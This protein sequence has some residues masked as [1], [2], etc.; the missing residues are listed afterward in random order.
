MPRRKRENDAL[1]DPR[2]TRPQLV[3]TQQISGTL[4]S[5]CPGQPLHTKHRNSNGNVERSASPNSVALKKRKK[6]LVPDTTP[7]ATEKS[8]ISPQIARLQAVEATAQRLWQDAVA[9]RKPVSVL[10]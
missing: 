4:S 1:V 5:P 6:K 8:P 2:Q 10:A 9:L 7:K 3:L